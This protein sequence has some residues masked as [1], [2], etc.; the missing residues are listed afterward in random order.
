MKKRLTRIVGIILIVIL[1]IPLIGPFLIPVPPLEDI[2]SLKHSRT[3]TASSSR[4]T[5]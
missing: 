4:S 5:D 1:A 3:R 2:V